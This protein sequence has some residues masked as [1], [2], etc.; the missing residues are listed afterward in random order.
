MLNVDFL[1]LHQDKSS[2]FYK[3]LRNMIDPILIT[4]FEKIGGFVRI[5]DVDFKKG[6]VIANVQTEFSSEN[7]QVSTVTLARAIIDASDENGNLGQI[8]SDIS[9][10]QQQI[11]SKTST[12]PPYDEDGDKDNNTLI[13]AVAAVVSGAIICVLLATFLV[14][15]IFIDNILTVII[16]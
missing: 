11:T 1:D 12:T 4:V 6:S 16:N 14:S 5:T 15:L 9:F 8:K 10:L 7:A 13:G 3:G 2:D